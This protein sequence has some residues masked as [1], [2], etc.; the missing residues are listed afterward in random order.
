MNARD[1]AIRSAI[2]AGLEGTD[3]EW[4]WHYV[5]LAEIL[6]KNQMYVSGDDIKAFC[7]ARQLWKPD[8]AQRWTGAPL[9]LVRKGWVEPLVFIKP[10]RPHN[11][12]PEVT[13]YH[14]K[15]YDES[16]WNE[17]YISRKSHKD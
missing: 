2:E 10:V 3:P 16:R 8:V 13:F 9:V 1:G 5:L 6:L 12:M 7:V 17:F 11:H 15:L 14:S 4:L